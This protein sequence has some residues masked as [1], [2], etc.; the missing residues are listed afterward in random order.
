MS[1]ALLGVGSGA[2]VSLAST[3]LLAHLLYGVGSADPVTFVSVALLLLGVSL[4]ASYGPARRA[5]RIA[6]QAALHYD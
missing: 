3:P 1:L 6:P 2:L 5:A 4:A